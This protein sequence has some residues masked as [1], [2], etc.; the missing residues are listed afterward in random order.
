MAEAAADI[1]LAMLTAAALGR[2][3]DPVKAVA[4]AV[5]GGSDSLALLAM[6]AAAF[7]GRTWVLTVDHGLRAGSRAEADTV[8]AICAARGIPHATLAWT[9]PKPAANRQ[10]AARAARYALMAQWCAAGD[11]PLLFTAHHADDQ[12]ETLLMRLARGS[13]SGGLAGIRAARPLAPSVTLVRPLLGIRR[14]ALAAVTAASGLVPADDPANRDPRFDR[15]RARALLAAAPWLD[16]GRLAESAAR[17]AD[18]EAALDWTAARAWAGRAVVSPGAVS[19][20]PAGLPGEIVHRLAARAIAELAPLTAPRGSAVAALTA[21]LSGGKT[22]TL[23][24]VRAAPGPVW[25]FTIAAPR[26]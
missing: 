15:T 18:A 26:R 9:G 21:R 11:V 16:A 14:M 13:G 10:A 7:P 22:A 24:G 23:A 6:A 19:L 3:V 17:L 5:S 25:R 1:D 8:G 2:P 20:D 12:A 4:V